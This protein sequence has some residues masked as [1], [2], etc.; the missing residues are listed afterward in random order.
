MSLGQTASQSESGSPAEPA[1]VNGAQPP[2]DDSGNVNPAPP[3]E[4]NGGEPA[5]GDE[6]ASWRQAISG[7]DEKMLETLSRFKTEADFG[8]SYMELRQKLSQ[9]PSLPTLPENAT[10]EQIA[11]YRQAIGA[12]ET[13]DQLREALVAPEGYE[14][15]EVEK[16][17]I[18]DFAQE[19]HAANIPVEH[20]KAATDFFFKAQ[21]AD[22]QAANQLDI[23]RAKEWQM[24]HEKELGSDYQTILSSAEAYLTNR[25]G[26][27]AEAKQELLNA[28]LPGGGRLGDN[29]AFIN[30]VAD[31]AMQN[32][33]GD[34]IEA[35]E[36]EAA[37]GKP[38]AQQVA[39]IEKLAMTDRATYD[40]PQT[41]KKLQR[42]IE[43]QLARGE[44]DE[45]GN[46]K[47]K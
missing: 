35:N 29:P 25:F 26:D 5:H 44:I 6:P 14:I 7:G 41:Q 22:M 47:R 30:M 46:P 27:N 9:G 11:D 24:S 20:A 31:L 32:G 10:P 17:M 16:A 15:S 1:A 43:L 8:K 23:D 3:A 21:A 28:R 36:I 2:A 12:A 37:G 19:M 38:L 33:Y 34:R 40:L 4:L 18:G 45:W 13:P 42:L 39:E